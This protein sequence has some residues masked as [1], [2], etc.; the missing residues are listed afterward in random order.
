MVVCMVCFGVKS[1]KTLSKNQTYVFE[2]CSI[3]GSQGFRRT[4]LTLLFLVES[5]VM[6]PGKL[7]IRVYT[8]V[9]FSFFYFVFLM[10]CLSSIEIVSRF[11]RQ[12]QTKDDVSTSQRLVLYSSVESGGDLV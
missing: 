12:K 7:S 3:Y 1:K 4:V 11:E 5:G 10:V 6:L 8:S 9:F 2:Y